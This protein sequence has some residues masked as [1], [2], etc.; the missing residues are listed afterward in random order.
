MILPHFQ[1][2]MGRGGRGGRT[3]AAQ[4][5]VGDVGQRLATTRE[6]GKEGGGGG[7]W[8]GGED[9]GKSTVC[10]MGWTDGGRT[11]H[12]KMKCCYIS[13][14]W[15]DIIIHA[16][17]EIRRPPASRVVSNLVQ[18]HGDNKEKHQ[19]PELPRPLP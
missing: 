11:R 12:R 16:E 5:E 17:S 18:N 4:F 3:V 19:N 6:E 2:G 15:T 14:L 7:R 10:G 13:T 1:I 9:R 8:G